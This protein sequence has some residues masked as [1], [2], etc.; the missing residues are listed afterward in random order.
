MIDK[1]MTLLDEDG[2]QYITQKLL[3]RAKNEE[4]YLT[5]DGHIAVLYHAPE[6]LRDVYLSRFYSLAHTRSL[7]PVLL[8]EAIL[9]VPNTGYITTPKKNMHLWSDEIKPEE[10]SVEDYEDWLA[11]RGGL[12]AHY[13]IANSLLHGLMTLHCEG[14]IIG[15]LHPEELGIEDE[16]HQVVFLRADGLMQLSSWHDETSA[17]NTVEENLHVLPILQSLLFP[18]PLDE[19]QETEIGD[20]ENEEDDVS[21]DAYLTDELRTLLFPE[22][23]P[24]RA[25]NLPISL[26]E[27]ST[28][29]ERAMQQLQCC[30]S[31]ETWY[32]S[33]AGQTNECPTCGWPEESSAG[34]RLCMQIQ[35]TKPLFAANENSRGN[36]IDLPPHTWI[37]SHGNQKLDIRPFLP[38]AIPVDKLT[39]LVSIELRSDGTIWLVN[40]TQKPLLHEQTTNKKDLVWPGEK[41]VQ[42]VRHESHIEFPELPLSV[43]GEE[44]ARTKIWMEIE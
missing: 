12:M 2:G 19:N 3:W 10:M 27:L 4:A 32:F 17:R 6:D 35:P 43:D 38:Q 39:P 7:A 16:T 14:R 29:C 23:S 40:E 42:L 1:E 37:F 5:T 21:I 25:P 41:P 9:S 8:P 36:A 28:A 31:C 18:W 15:T 44:I 11:E 13:E 30:P 26:A 33:N 24:E 20:Q 22:I 34:A